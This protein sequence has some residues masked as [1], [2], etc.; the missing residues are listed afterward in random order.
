MLNS[1][2]IVPRSY[3]W[4]VKRLSCCRLS[5]W[6]SSG[7]PTEFLRSS[8][9]RRRWLIGSAEGYKTLQHGA[10]GTP[11]AQHSEC[12]PSHSFTQNAAHTIALGFVVLRVHLPQ[13]CRSLLESTAAKCSPYYSAA[14]IFYKKIGF[15]LLQH[16]HPHNCEQ[17]PI[18][19]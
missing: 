16:F 9:G 8:F 7:V 3:P 14:R 4:S 10:T 2:S 1:C 5:S 11:R 13:K 6:N 19:R 18:V 17:A 12:I 15:A